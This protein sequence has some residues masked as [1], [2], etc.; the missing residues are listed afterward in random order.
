MFYIL[1]KYSHSLNVLNFFHI[2]TVIKNQHKGS[3]NHEVEEKS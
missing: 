3:Y 1:E 2:A